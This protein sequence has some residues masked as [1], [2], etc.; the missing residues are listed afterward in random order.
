MSSLPLPPDRSVASISSDSEVKQL[1]DFLSTSGSG[2]DSFSDMASSSQS[3]HLSDAIRLRI[4]AQKKDS[5]IA[6]LKA[7]VADLVKYKDQNGNLRAQ[8]AIIQEQ[9]R[10]REYEMTQKLDEMRERLSQQTATDATLRSQQIHVEREK[11]ELS[12]HFNIQVP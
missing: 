6:D 11:L 8:I 9:S 10:L 12:R 5:W 2:N 4:D 3:D 1:R 7:Q